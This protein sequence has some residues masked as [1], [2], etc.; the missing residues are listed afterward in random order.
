M[1]ITLQPLFG[2]IIDLIYQRAKYFIARKS[3]KEKAKPP[4]DHAKQQFLP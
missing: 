1:Y 2:I 3:A 4:A